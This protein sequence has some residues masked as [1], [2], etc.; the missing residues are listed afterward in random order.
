MSHE[1]HLLIKGAKNQN[2]FIMDSNLHFIWW[3]QFLPASPLIIDV[4]G[5]I[6]EGV[7]EQSRMWETR[8]SRHENTSMPP[9]RFLLSPSDW[10]LCSRRRLVFWLVLLLFS[11]RASVHVSSKFLSSLCP[12]KTGAFCAGFSDCH[13]RSLSLG[14]F[15][16][17]NMKT[18]QHKNCRRRQIIPKG[19]SHLHF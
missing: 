8:V 12:D 15:F 4:G 2:T 18:K 19:H 6:L 1:C 10:S 17:F 14:Q 13:L 7:N 3:S 5:A 9:M 11:P 16:Q